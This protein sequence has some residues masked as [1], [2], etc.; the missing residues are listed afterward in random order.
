MNIEFY[1]EHLQTLCELKELADKHGCS[2]YFGVNQSTA[3][4]SLEEFDGYTEEIYQELYD[5][6]YFDNWRGDVTTIWFELY[7]PN[8]KDKKY[9]SLSYS[10][11][12]R[13]V[14]YKKYCDEDLSEQTEAFVRENLLSWQDYNIDDELLLYARIYG[15]KM[16]GFPNQECP[17]VYRSGMALKFFGDLVCDYLKEPRIIRTY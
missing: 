5:K 8:N 15:T 2:I 13:C 9:H 12:D 11:G 14:T 4:E 16:A 3:N 6:G 7:D 17:N 1:T 10:D